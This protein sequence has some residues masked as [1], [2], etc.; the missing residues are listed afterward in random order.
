M[1]SRLKGRTIEEKLR[2]NSVEDSNGCWLWQGGK[3]TFGHGIIA[4]NRKSHLAHRVAYKI[5]KD[6]VPLNMFV[7]HTCDN[8]KCI[9]PDHLFIGTQDDNMKDMANKGRSNNGIQKGEKN[10]QS[11]L[12]DRQ[13]RRIKRLLLNGHTRKEIA[14]KFGVNEAV[15]G[16]ISEN[17]NWKHVPWP[18]IRHKKVN[19]HAG[20]RNGRALLTEDQ[21]VE[22]KKQL[23]D[24][25][26]LKDIAVSFGVG[27][28]V[29]R[30]IKKGLTWK[31]VEINY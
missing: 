16:F 12:T 4:V 28:H 25:K 6:R 14:N 1:A 9:N 23:L 31:H 13:V 5:W 11:Q 20:E 7:C 10:P 27:D 26:R 2:F 22:I 8:P 19:K 29:I 17:K 24:N 21:V 3:T 30:F 15:V 18:K